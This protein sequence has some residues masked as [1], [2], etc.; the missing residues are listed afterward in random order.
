VQLAEEGAIP[1]RFNKVGRWWD[2]SHEI[3]VVALD[4]AGRDI[5]FGEC[6]YTEEPMDTDVYYRLQENKNAV[7]WN[8]ASRNEYFVFFSINGYTE[9]MR[10]LAAAKGNVALS[11]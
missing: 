9:Q 5:V 6:K 4:S 1:R 2:G 10:S 7:R 8:A 11:E 3:D